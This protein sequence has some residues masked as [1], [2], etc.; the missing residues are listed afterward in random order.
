MWKKGSD[1]PFLSF[2][3]LA[4]RFVEFSPHLSL[5]KGR[6][7]KKKLFEEM[8]PFQEKIHVAKK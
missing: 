8:R 2:S 1:F 6:L 5:F 4:I 7:K 3:T